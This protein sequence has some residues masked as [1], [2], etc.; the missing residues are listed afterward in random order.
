MNFL[1]WWLPRVCRLCDRT[2]DRD[3]DLCA[4]CERSL[5]WNHWPC[6]RCGV[7]LR[8]GAAPLNAL[9]GLPGRATRDRE[10]PL[11]GMNADQ[12]PSGQ[13]ASEW[14]APPQR[15]AR[16]LCGR[17]I[18]QPPPMCRTLAPLLFEGPVRHWVHAA[19]FGSGFGEA[20]LLSA[21]LARGIASSGAPLPDGL[22]PVPLS[23]ARLFRRGHN[24]AVL[25]ALPLSRRFGIELHRRGMQRLG[26]KSQRGQSRSERAASVQGAFRATRRFSGRLAIVDDVMTTGAT[27]AE[28]ARSLLEA[29]AEQVE[30]WAA[31][32]VAQAF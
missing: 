7:P 29:G 20:K 9:A 21:L 30:V 10:R 32:R 25:L 22:V 23:P 17:C 26:G 12:P 8:I 4:S 16:D 27:A 14:N 24:Q 1:D 6:R 11:A 28:L 19:K 13:P 18:D 3:L 15:E 2:I 5:P 31:A